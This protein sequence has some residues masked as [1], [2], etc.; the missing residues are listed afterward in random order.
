MELCKYDLESLLKKHGK[1]PESVWQFYLFLLFL[2][3]F[4]IIY[5]YVCIYIMY[6][7]IGNY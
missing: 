2:L 7:Y 4:I 5:M 6:M 3:L 1:L